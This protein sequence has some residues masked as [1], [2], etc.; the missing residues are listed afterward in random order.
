MV[1]SWIIRFAGADLRGAAR[2]SE[3]RGRAENRHLCIVEAMKPQ[4]M[5]GEEGLDE[6]AYI[7]IPM[8][9]FKRR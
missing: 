5:S 6:F 7:K 1:I 9:G 2:A 3:L 8:G 4:R